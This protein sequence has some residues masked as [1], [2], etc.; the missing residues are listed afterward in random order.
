LRVADLVLNNETRE[1]MR[2]KEVIDLTPKE[3]AMAIR[4]GIVQG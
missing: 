4:S 3:F 2:G 1:V